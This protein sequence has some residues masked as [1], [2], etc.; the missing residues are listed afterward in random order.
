MPRLKTPHERLYAKTVFENGCLRWTA[1]KT[2]EGFAYFSY[3]GD[4]CM[5]HRVAWELAFGPI[6]EGACVTHTCANADCVNPAHLRL[7][8]WPSIHARTLKR[9]QQRALDDEALRLLASLKLKG[10]SAP[11]FLRVW[12]HQTGK[13]CCVETVYLTLKTDR[14][15]AI[16]RELEEQKAPAKQEKG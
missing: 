1:G 14:Y 11:T 15:L 8:Y 5:G 2:K 10:K 7:E 4:G 9:E 3:K 13:R 12:K 6:P 16:R